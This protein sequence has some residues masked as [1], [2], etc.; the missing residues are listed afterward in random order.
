MEFKKV[1]IL[2]GGLLGGSL[3][4]A[5]L[6]RF[7]EL[8]VSL[9]SR[10]LKNVEAAKARGITGATDGLGTAVDGADLVVLS[11]PV[12]AMA[13]VL[14]NAQGSGL[15]RGALIT[16]VGSVKAA[17]HRSLRPILAPTKGMFI[18]SHPMAGSEKTGVEAASK[19]LFQGAAC[20]VTDEDKVGDPWL[21]RL[22][23]FWEALGCRVFLPPDGA[24]H[25]IAVANVSHYP[26]MMA[27]AA[28]RAAL[29]GGLEYGKISGGGLRDTTRV[30]SGDP[31]MW[32]EIAIE[33]KEALAKVLRA[34][35]SDLSEM[36]AKL[37]EGDQ[38]ALRVWLAVAKNAR[39]TA[40]PRV[41]NDFP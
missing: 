19:D 41:R 23:S 1:A 27:A 4:L 15:S 14:L 39:D 37:E 11:T 30:A 35:I 36:L 12:G 34:S 20:L 33:N 3:A 25:D 32:A 9:W 18:G 21:G 5:L 28:A 24:E 13:P 6:E 40:L 26:H 31:Q 17:V 29:S 2:G 8:P 38:E 10:R 7:P 16:D 22:K